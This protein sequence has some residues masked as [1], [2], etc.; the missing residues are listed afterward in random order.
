MFKGNSFYER[1]EDYYRNKFARN[2]SSYQEERKSRYYGFLGV[3]GDLFQRRKLIERRPFPSI[4][5]TS[6]IF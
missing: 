6:M 3:K 2:E 5:E 1:K 4:Y